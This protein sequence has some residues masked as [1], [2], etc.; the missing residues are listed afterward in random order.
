MRENG[1]RLSTAELLEMLFKEK[2]LDS[3]FE[4]NADSFDTQLFCDYIT[5]LC[6]DKEEVAEKIIERAGMEKSYGHKLFSGTRNPSRD[7]VIRLAFGFEADM[8]LAQQ[9]LKIARKSILY[10]R[11]KRDMAI[12][13]CL[14]NHL[15]IVET[16]IMLSDLGLPLLGEG[17]R[18]E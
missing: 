4:K 10:P 15:S 5:V 9:L 14:H 3:L 1:R 17:N 2:R 8:D 12:I 16:Q 7:T 11:V 13:Y 6:R 18:N